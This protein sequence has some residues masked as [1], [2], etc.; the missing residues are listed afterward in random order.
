MALGMTKPL[1][2]L[3]TRNLNREEG[4]VHSQN[5]I[6]LHGLLQG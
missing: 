3:S 6:G 2:E 5:V 1:I 4:A